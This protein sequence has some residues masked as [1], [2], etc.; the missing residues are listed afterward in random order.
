MCSAP[1]LTQP[2]FNKKFYLQVDASGFGVGT[3]LL[4][5]SDITTPS[6]AKRTKP[7]LH[8]IAYYSATFTPTERNYDIYERE[9]LAIMKSLTHWRPYLGWTKETFTILTDHAN[10][11][12]W[13]APKNLNRRTAQWHT[14]LQE[15]DY[16]I[17]HIPGSTNIPADALSRPPGVD[18]GKE[19]NQNVAVI[20]PEKFMTINTTIT[21]QDETTLE[22]WAKTQ[23]IYHRTQK[24]GATSY[25]T[26]MGNKDVI[27]PGQQRA[28]MV[29]MHDHQS[30]GHPRINET[31]KKTKEKYWWPSMMKWIQQY[32]EQCTTCQQNNK[33]TN[34]RIANEDSSGSLEEK[35]V[36]MQNNYH[37]ILNNTTKY[38][39]LEQIP[40]SEGFI[41]R[42]QEG[43]LVVPSDD[44]IRRE[45]MNI[46]HDIPAAGHPGRDET[47]R[48]ITEQ[49]HWP[50][51]RQ[52][53]AEYIKGCAICQQNKI[54]TH[55]EKTPLY[56]IG[57]K[58]NAR[59]FE[60]IAMDLITGL[61]PRNGKN[62]ILTIVDHGCSRA[63]IFLP[64]SDTIT[65]PGIA[66]LYLDNVFCWFGLPTKMISDRDPRFTSHFGRA[67]TQKLGVQQ[68]LSTAFHPQ[69]DGLSE[70]KNQWVEQYLRLVTSMQ[71]EDW[72][73]WLSMA[74]AVHNN[75]KN[76]T[77]G[78]SPNQV[79]LGYDIPLIPDHMGFSNNE[80]AEQRLDIMK[81]RREQAIEALNLM[82]NKMS[83][84]ETRY[85]LGDQVWLEATHLRLPH[86]KS[87]LVPKRMG[88]FRINKVVS[89]VAYQLALPAAWRIHD[90][91][92]ASLLSPYHETQAHGPNFYRPPPDLI[93]GEEE[94]EVERIATHK[95]H[96]KSQSLQ[97]L[98]K[99]KGY[100]EADN[101]WEPADQIHAP[102][103][104]KTYHRHNPL[105]RI[106]EALLIQSSNNV[107][108]P[109]STSVCLRSCSNS[110]VP[111][112]PLPPRV[113]VTSSSTSSSIQSNAS[114]SVPCVPSAYALAPDSSST[115]PSPTNS[116]PPSSIVSDLK[117]CQITIP[118]PLIVHSAVPSARG[119]S[120]QIRHF[121]PTSARMPQNL[122]V[123]TPVLIAHLRP[124][125]VQ[126]SKS[127]SPLI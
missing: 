50:G 67:L 86:Q 72:T 52:W 103:L 13:K 7:A 60:H 37:E 71:P 19:D 89:P 114:T 80:G 3:V 61:P 106:K 81:K 36:Q 25:Q 38:Q 11:Q 84:P 112:V 64:C 109:L 91:F 8:P 58:S 1:V 104:L 97:Y 27:P 108:S 9:L 24:N 32:V 82:A 31:I 125:S 116:V 76:A 14:D 47:T 98:I 44:N 78:V 105:E 59:P 99:W 79:L 41:W 101:T 126:R 53:I 93:D 87:K 18:K 121:K 75:R 23:P 20:P 6:L 34:I 95:Y 21:N 35:I 33:V 85:K 30:A 90:V 39:S 5:E 62:A 124:S 12:Y 115:F 2:D 100:P 29:L 77:T 88:P 63:A 70:R 46:W 22:T 96:G 122:N 10:L 92:H 69:T 119:L 113:T 48:R 127:I 43:K 26:L 65:E 28:I 102:D 117:Q 49:Y 56:R 68:N 42:N 40:D 118:R 111:T 123:A 73:E 107:L 45:I 94:Y 16:E 66:Q 55:R 83:T 54:L 57:T 15:Y 110:I 51:A 74:T 17:K 120:D 4:Q